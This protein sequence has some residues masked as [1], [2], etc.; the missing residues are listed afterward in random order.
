MHFHV[1]FISSF[2]TTWYR[3]LDKDGRVFH[4]IFMSTNLVSHQKS[5]V[6]I[7]SILA[8]AGVVASVY[9]YLQYQHS[10]QLLKNPTLAGQIEVNDLVSR[11][12]VLMV[13]PKDEQ[14]TIATVSDYKQLKDQPFFI[15][16]V[17]GDK[18][19]IYTKAK[20]AIL[21]DPKV[22]KIIQVAPVNLGNAASPIGAS[23]KIALYNGTATSGATAMVEN[24]LKTK[25]NNITITT[26]TSAKGEYAK[27][28]VVDLT[29]QNATSVGQLA[30]LL[31]GEVS[32]LPSSEIKP[33]N[34]DILVIVGSSQ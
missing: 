32:T 19:L 13:L 3:L 34:A 31:N 16:A 14:P 30:S 22:N 8:A 10:Q 7:L 23:M 4:T 2:Q 9:F 21:Y 18:V 26:K 28:L 27:N 20:E 17:N 25:V 5:L 29:G 11:V 33:T 12:G 6:T 1:Y 15:H 24:E